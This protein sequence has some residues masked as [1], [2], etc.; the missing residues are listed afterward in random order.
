MMLMRNMGR[1]GWM[2]WAICVTLSGLAALFAA[3]GSSLSPQARFPIEE[4]TLAVTFPAA[5]ALIVT[6]RPR[7]PIGW[8]FCAI[9]LSHALSIFSFYAILP[10]VSAAADGNPFARRLAWIAAWPWWGLGFGLLPFLFLLFPSGRLPSPRWRW[11]GWLA[12][13]GMAMLVLP[14]II[15]SWSFTVPQLLDLSS[16]MEAT[17]AGH[18]ANMV[19]I[20]GVALLFISALGAAISLILR[21]RGAVGIERQQ[22]K[23]FAYACALFILCRLLILVFFGDQPEG[24]L[25][26]AAGVL[27]IAGIPLAVGIAILRYRL[28]DIDIIINRTLVYGLLTASLALMYIGYIVV[29]RQVLA[30][31]TGSSEL[32]IVASTLAIAAL[33]NPLRRR[34]QNLIDQRFYRR[35]YD[36]A[37]V[38][39]AFA[40]TVRDETDLDALTTEVLRVV[41]ETMQ[42][43]FVGLWLKETTSDQR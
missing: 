19:L 23:W 24:P 37:T 9:G 25:P 39:A 28:Y 18:I 21:L 26:I 40:A 4:L 22:L 35:K 34:I 8:I 42:P 30:P 17:G 3:R 12:G 7:N 15:F 13:V 38:L 31:L 16:S 2:I 11:L 41:D 29:L 1:L 36:A 6:R 20:A 10:F 27:A 33:F 32:A 14:Q 5:G 43:E